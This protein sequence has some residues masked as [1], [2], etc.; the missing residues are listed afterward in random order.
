[1][2]RVPRAVGVAV[3]SVA[4]RARRR[5]LPLPLPGPRAPPDQPLFR[6]GCAE[7]RSGRLGLGW[8]GAGA[9]AAAADRPRHR[10][11]GPGPLPHATRP[12]G[13]AVLLPAAAAALLRAAPRLGSA[14]GPLRRRLPPAP[15]MPGPAAGSRARV[16][17]EVNSVKSR[18]YWDYEAHVPSWG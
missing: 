8:A 5:P 14:A 6:V 2:R 11:R 4:G 3:A 7:L 15:A 9:A 13:L 10:P 1:M 12:A 16:Y 18:E 17:A